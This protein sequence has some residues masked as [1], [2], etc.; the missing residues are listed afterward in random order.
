MTTQTCD[1]CGMPLRT[2]ED[3]APGHDALCNYCAPGGTLQPFDER[4]ERM[5]QWSMRQNGLDR[6]A[7]EQATRDYMR[8]MPAWKD[9][10]ALA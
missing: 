4:F 2:A 6:P 10:P 9:N 3:H 5:V 7:A 1:S 8:T